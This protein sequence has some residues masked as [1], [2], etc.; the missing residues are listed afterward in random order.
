MVAGGLVGP[1]LTLVRGIFRD[2]RQGTGLVNSTRDI[3][4]SLAWNVH[5]DKYPCIYTSL[6]TGMGDSFSVVGPISDASIQEIF[7]NGERVV[8]TRVRLNFRDGYLLGF[9]GVVHYNLSVSGTDYIC[10]CSNSRRSSS[11]F[12]HHLFCFSFCCCSVERYRYSMPSSL[13]R[14]V[15]LSSFGP[16]IRV[17]TSS[18][19][20]R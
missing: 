1:A 8:S 13:E 15:S 17:L 12:V 10:Y 19:Q 5:M 9:V 2:L 20:D 14:L 18:I 6:R 4:G 3:C 16:K 7:R 11:D